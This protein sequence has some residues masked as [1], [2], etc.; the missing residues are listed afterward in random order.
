MAVGKK[1]NAKSKTQNGIKQG[2]SSSGARDTRDTSP[3]RTMDELLARTGYQL[4]GF[5]RGDKVKG[6]VLDIGPKFIIL[7]IGAKSEGVVTDREFETIKHFVKN[8]SVG[9]IV[10]VQIL[11][12]EEKGQI[13]LSIREAA[14]KYAWKVL[15]DAV[16]ASREIDCRVESV[17]RGG[18][19]VLVMGLNGYIPGSH[20]GNSLAKN[21]SS[22]LDK[23]LK[24]KVIEADREK[25]RIVL[26]EK[27]VSEAE[28]LA[29]QEEIVKKIK[30]GEKFRGKVVGIVSF[31]AFVQIEKDKVALDGLVH[32]SELSWQKVSSPEEVVKVGDE[33][34]VVVIGRDPSKGSGQG[35][36]LS[37]SMKQAQEDPW[38]KVV[39]KY[40]EEGRVKG[41]V[42]RLGDFGAIIGLEP[43]IEGLV[44]LS[45]IPA[46]IS[47]KEGAEIDCF[48]EK[49]DQKSRKI[50][51][52]LVLKA[53]PVG[54][55]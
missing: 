1:Q 52:G 34:S 55:K 19:S 42:T 30:E 43:G 27:A 5:S 44:H 2:K 33:V 24:V 49:V 26:S 12:P 47:L 20:L 28:L 18:L 11:S 4:K 54:Y 17:A 25:N 53:K 46:G 22:A 23:T 3:A 31:G 40:K 6:K 16:L 51:L 14:E 48:I 36:R 10:E 35:G 29:L 50:S 38:K 15:E 39:K 9:D 8:L 32:L 7:D 13:V 21:P 37:F 41:K 45:K